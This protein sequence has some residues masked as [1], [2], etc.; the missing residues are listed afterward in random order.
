MLERQRRDAR[1]A[2]LRRP[3]VRVLGN[4]D[5]RVDRCSEA[6]YISRYLL[7]RGQSITIHT[8]WAIH[9]LLVVSHSPRCFE[10]EVPW[11]RPIVGV[12]YILVRD[13]I[14]FRKKS[15]A[16]TFKPRSSPARIPGPVA[17]ARR[18]LQPATA[19][20]RTFPAEAMCCRECFMRRAHRTE[21]APTAC[22]DSRRR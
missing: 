18:T 8:T 7:P 16:S 3:G 13:K 4:S 22:Y 20:P 11:N 14:T 15:M 5:T 10:V 6:I 19:A 9:C 2:T 12:D 1:A 21:T 17:V